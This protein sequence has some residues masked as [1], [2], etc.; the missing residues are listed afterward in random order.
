MKILISWLVTAVLLVVLREPLRANDNIVILLDNSGSMNDPMRPSNIRRIDAAK[1]AIIQVV[2]HLEGETK[3]GIMLLNPIRGKQLWL[4]PL[5]PL[6]VSTVEANLEPLQAKEGTPLGDRM[7]EAADELLKLRSERIYG[8]FRLVVVTDGEATDKERLDRYLPDILSR[9][10]IVDV[11]GVDMRQD[12]SLASS[13][14]RYRRADD[15]QGLNRAIADVM[16]ESVTTGDGNE[17]E[18]EIIAGLESDMARA[19]LGALSKTNND[20]IAGSRRVEPMHVDSGSGV[21]SN[22]TNTS[23]AIATP[24]NASSVIAVRWLGFAVFLCGTPLLV[25]FLLLWSVLHK[26]K[27]GGSRRNRNF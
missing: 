15:E 6:S 20:P 7:R 9:G 8:T 18:F 11:I 24:S 22:A 27:K 23:S 16:A 26:S 10:L 21:P 14:H 25:M 12:H 17:R 2:R 19:V 4:V 3:L 13:A 1:R 5:G